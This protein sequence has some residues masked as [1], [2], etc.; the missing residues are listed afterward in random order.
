MPDVTL[1]ARAAPIVTA[2]SEGDRVTIGTTHQFR[3]D[4]HDSWVKAEVNSAVRYNETP[5][6]AF[7]RIGGALAGLIVN[8]IERQAGV[9]AD[10]N[11]AQRKK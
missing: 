8:E 11:A 6:D 2:I 9:I 4:G 10:A 1:P 5:E 7:N 3:I